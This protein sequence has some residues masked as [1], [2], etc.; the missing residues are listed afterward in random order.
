MVKRIAITVGEPAG[1][2]PDIVLKIAQ[3]HWSAVL[4]AVADI[5]ML[6]SR[7]DLLN[8][9]IVLKMYDP[10][11]PPE[12]HEAGCL[13]VLNIPQ[14][15]PTKP[16]ILDA[17]NRNAVLSALSQAAEGCLAKNFDALVTA[18]VQKSHLTTHADPFRG[19]TEFFA[20]KAGVPLTVMLLQANELRVA[21]HTTHIPLMDVPSHITEASLTQTLRVLEEGLRSQFNIAKPHIGV[22][23]LNP[24]AGESGHAGLEEISVIAPVIKKLQADGMHLTGPIS[25]D[26]AFVPDR[27]RTFDAVLAMYHD[28]GLAPLKCV[29]FGHAVNVT[30][31][32]PFIRTS[33]DHGTALDIAGTGHASDSSLRA[34]IELACRLK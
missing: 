27:W 25:A 22:V 20:D 29:G 24:H 17:R 32:L 4:I 14:A 10:L 1:I 21:L 11:H 28:Q 33:V 19:H 34:A 7:A 5:T 6:Q 13:W 26:T 30:L 8:L 3:D 12:T 16:G 9:P 31:G 2:G 15:V 18:P 23:G